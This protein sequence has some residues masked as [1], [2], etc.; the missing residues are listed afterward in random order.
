MT[1]QEKKLKEAILVLYYEI[2]HKTQGNLP[3][4]VEMMMSAAKLDAAK[5]YWQQQQTS[6]REFTREDMLLFA[7]HVADI[8]FECSQTNPKRITEAI[9]VILEK[10]EQTSAIDWK[11]LRDKF[12]NE[13]VGNTFEKR[14]VVITLKLN[15]GTHDLFDWFKKEIEQQLNKNK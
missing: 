8:I 4:V 2:E 13:C 12:Y 11:E 6:E 7:R 3:D 5:E 15:I 9:Y 1:E 10:V 14:D